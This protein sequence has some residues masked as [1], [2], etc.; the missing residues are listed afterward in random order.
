VS[1]AIGID[2]NGLGPRLGPM[3]VTAVMARTSGG[4]RAVV[5]QKARGDLARR[6]GD[7]KGLVS[8]RKIGLA[9]AWTRALVTRGAGQT[10]AGDDRARHTPQQLLA[11][12]SLDDQASLQAPCPKGLQAQCWSYPASP[13]P[14]VDAQADLD[15]SRVL[16]ADLDGLERQGVHI[17]AVRSVVLCPKRL[18]DAAA[19]GVNRLVADLH[20]ME[21]LILHLRAL[22]GE[23]IDAV[24]GKVGGLMRYGR[25][26]GPLAGHLHTVLREE[27]ARSAYRFADIGT[28]SFVRNVDDTNLL[29][30]LASL[31]G[32]YLRELLM[33]NIV[34]HYREADASLPRASGYHDPVTARFVSG[35]QALRRE[36]K[37]PDTCFER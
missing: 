23:D 35:S 17:I 12:L 9:E 29:V 22:A 32:K 14:E 19:A 24:C 27:R 7:S 13:P 26:F 36:R 18:N 2:E 6:L 30:G 11:A 34:N 31:V 33:G 25:A 10:G 20:A 5:E 15:L 37:V 3:I 28:V 21:R 16:A 1:Y 8:H 4:G